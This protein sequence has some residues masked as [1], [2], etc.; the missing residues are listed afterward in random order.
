MWSRVWVG[1]R[2][3]NICQRQDCFEITVNFQLQLSILCIHNLKILQIL[4]IYNIIVP[5]NISQYSKITC[6]L[7]SHSV[8]LWWITH[9]SWLWFAGSDAV[10]RIKAYT[11]P[12]RDAAASLH[13]VKF[14]SYNKAAGRANKLCSVPVRGKPRLLELEQVEPVRSVEN[15]AHSAFIRLSVAHV[16][17]RG[18]PKKINK[19]FLWSDF[20]FSKNGKESINPCELEKNKMWV[21]QF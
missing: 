6:L 11:N 18:W 4:I 5:Q 16:W 7:H 17:N 10:C 20:V 15:P 14:R 13:W 9:A 3:E 1:G 8:S 12:T 19:S 2:E 21:E